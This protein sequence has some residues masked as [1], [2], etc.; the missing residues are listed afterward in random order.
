MDWCHKSR[1]SIFC[2]LLLACSACGKE[3]TESVQGFVGEELESRHFDQRGA[4][5]E[6]LLFFLNHP[7]TTVALLDSVVELDRR[8]AE[9]LINHRNGADGVFGTT[10]D[11]PFD[12]INEVDSIEWV[13][14]KALGLLKEYAINNGWIDENE[15]LLG[16][17]DGVSFTVSESH[18]VLTLVNEW[19]VD[20]LDR[21]IDRRAA[22]TIVE[23][24][25][26][27]SIRALS[28]VKWL[29]PRGL[30]ALK[31]AAKKDT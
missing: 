17:Y 21:L 9:G 23:Q 14:P 5:V 8:V 22:E 20:Q 29:G 10:D 28:E 2:L 27:A 11:D 6:G 7:S 30:V 31:G 25:P 18:S 16:V 19:S 12:S 3:P 26:Y 13:G 1:L 4:L 15:P 24:R